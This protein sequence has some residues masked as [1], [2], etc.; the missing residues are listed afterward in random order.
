MKRHRQLKGSRNCAAAKPT[1]EN[2][3]AM[4]LSTPV[5][6]TQ[7]SPPNSSANSPCRVNRPVPLGNSHFPHC[8]LEQA[9]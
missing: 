4:P 2:D 8:R 9:M 3:A 5:A 7:L 1:M 6:G